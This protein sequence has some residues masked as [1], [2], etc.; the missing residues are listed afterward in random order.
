MDD[1]HRIAVVDT[2]TL[3][4]GVSIPEQL[5]RYQFSNHLGSVNLELDD[6]AQVITYEE[7]SPYGSTLYSLQYI[8][9][10]MN[11]ACVQRNSN[12]AAYDNTVDLL[13]E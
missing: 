7:Y 1:Q 2:R 5:I 10:H 13:L 4:N 3:E 12:I 11:L 9:V 6:L 8:L